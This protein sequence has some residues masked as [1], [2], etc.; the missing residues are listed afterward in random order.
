[1]SVRYWKPEYCR[2]KSDSDGKRREG[3]RGERVPYP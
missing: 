1:M 3:R 2:Q